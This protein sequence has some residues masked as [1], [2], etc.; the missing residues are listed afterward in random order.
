MTL[1]H[2]MPLHSMRYTLEGLH[3][4]GHLV[5]FSGV[6]TAKVCNKNLLKL[7]LTYYALPKLMKN[8]GPVA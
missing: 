1:K 5:R 2:I 4:P 8:M 7:S 6:Y 3:D